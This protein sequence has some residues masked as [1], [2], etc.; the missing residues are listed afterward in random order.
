MNQTTRTPAPDAARLYE[1][2][3]AAYWE[4]AWPLGNGSLG[5]MI[6]GGYDEDRI[7]LNHDTLWTGYPRAGEYRGRA[8]SLDRVRELVRAGRYAQADKELADGFAGYASEA[9]LPLG[10]LTVEYGDRTSPVSRY[11]RRLEL[12]R[13]LYTASWCRG[14]RRCGVTAFASF[15]DRVLVYRAEAQGG[16]LNCEFVLRSPLWSRLW[17]DADGLYL[18]GECP[19]NSEQNMK[20]TDRRELY[21]EGS[22]GRGVRFLCALAVVTDGKARYRGDRATVSGAGYAEVYLCCAT[23]FDADSRTPDGQDYRAVCRETLKQALARGYRRI[24]AAHTADVSGYFDRCGL[25]TGSANRARVPTSR[26]LAEYA[27][28]ADDPALPALLFH[29]ARYLTIAASREGSQPMNL[30]GLWNPHLLAPW[31]AN[32]TLNIN[33]EMNYFATQALNLGELER[34]LLQMIAG[35]AERGRDTA[36]ELYHAPGWVCHHNTDIWLHTQPMAGVAC[37]SFWNAAGGWLCHHLYSYYEYTLDKTFL[38]ET[39]FPIMRGAAEFYLSQLETLPD[40]SRAVFPSTS[41]ENR[42]QAPEGPAAVSETAE[43]T[44]AIVR[45]LFSNLTKAAA[46]LEI[47]DGVSDRAAAELPHLRRPAVGQDGRLLEW[48]GEHP[49]YEP[50]HHHISHLYA[51]HPGNEITP[52]RTPE[53]CE[54]CR[55]TLAVRGDEG[56]GWSLAWKSN[57][58][59]RLGEGNHALALIRRQLRPSDSYGAGYSQHGGTYP[60][61]LCAHPPFQIDGNL[62]A[63]SG[64]CE[65]L[66]RSDTEILRLL[67]ACPDGWE[68]L[69]VWGLC[70]KGG[71]QVCFALRDGALTSCEIKGPRPAA[72]FLRGED[73]TGRFRYSEAT[74]TATLTAQTAGRPP[75]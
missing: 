71:R 63:A 15:P 43:M 57:C 1:R 62:G 23:S 27:A 39:A 70:A 50:C 56:T 22:A 74:Q 21:P 9:Y 26:R 29:Y 2:A 49:E 65:M 58:Y 72:V 17:S 14:G 11:A 25:N 69:S 38:R 35:L 12:R 31:H 18:E 19:C 10:E 60:N 75:V 45:E 7:C 4:Q 24:R 5:A 46:I 73:I 30:Q 3:P 67:P 36:R 68:T 33:T 48:Y 32:Y 37:Y 13:A 51:L 8:G 52:E 54:A 42:Y 59:A 34:P 28:G 53:L 40:G 55:R 16:G 41:P 20:L 66:L 64:I 61:L 44:M 6:Y 47:R